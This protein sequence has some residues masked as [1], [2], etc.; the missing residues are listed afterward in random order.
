[1]RQEPPLEVDDEKGF[2]AG[3][4]HFHEGCDEHYFKSLCSET[5]VTRR[6]AHGYTVRH[7][8]RSNY[9]RNEVLDCRVYARAAASLAGV[10][11][12]DPAEWARRRLELGRSVARANPKD[13]RRSK[14]RAAR[15]GRPRGSGRWRG[16]PQT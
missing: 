3:F 1:M 9:E 13:A 2:P 16:R 7:W 14:A 6:N 8:E 11:R 15:P 10:D 5:L 12:W 4:C